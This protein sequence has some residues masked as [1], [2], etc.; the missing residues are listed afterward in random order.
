MQNTITIHDD[1]REIGTETLDNQNRLILGD[2]FKGSTRVRVYQSDQGDILLQPL[3]DI[4][5]SERWLF[6]N[7][8]A[9]ESVQ[10][11]LQEASEGKVIKLVLDEL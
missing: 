2:I 3:A 1:F 8:E 6:H 9:L 10:R 5:E 7:K 11:G 4:P